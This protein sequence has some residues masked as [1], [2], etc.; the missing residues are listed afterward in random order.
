VPLSDYIAKNK[1]SILS[2]W[3]AFAR[4]H[5]P[6]ARDLEDRELEDPTADVLAA[7]AARLGD[8]ADPLAGVDTAP[9]AIVHAAHVHAELR[10]RQSFTLDQMIAEY[11]VLRAEVV[12]GWSHQTGLA[13]NEAIDELARFD[14]VIDH[15]S[16][17]TIKWFYDR[18]ERGRDLFVGVLAHD[19]RTPLGA[20]LASIDFLLGTDELAGDSLD[21]ALQIRKS[22]A[23]LRL[24]ANDL[25]DF[26][27]TRLGSALPLTREPLDLG[28][29]CRETV[30]ELEALHPAATIHLRCSGDLHGSWDGARLAQMLSN[31]IANAIEHGMAGEPIRVAARGRADADVVLQV[32][33]R[34]PP[35]PP[36]I[37]EVMLDPLKHLPL[38]EPQVRSR[39]RGLG[40]GLF[41]ARLIAEAHSGRIE[42]ESKGGDRTRVRVELPRRVPPPP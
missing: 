20:I 24:L 34:G 29:L 14:A 31:L 32:E 27:R 17:E 1:E 33:N 26:T 35:V 18:V 22:A 4:Q 8:T 30:K 21:A 3:V 16:T 25:L 10:L 28:P 15:G 5:V 36:A 42:L 9:A 2:D 37:R 7:I 40:L 19:V 12:R 39:A 41:I 6:A 23:R 13:H 38:L 11:R